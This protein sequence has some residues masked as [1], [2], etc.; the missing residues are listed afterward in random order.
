MYETGE[1]SKKML[2]AESGSFG[3]STNLLK[4]YDIQAIRT[5]KI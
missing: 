5:I 3:T 4:G 1:P 2:L